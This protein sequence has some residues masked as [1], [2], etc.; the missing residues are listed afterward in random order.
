MEVEVKVK[1]SLWMLGSSLIRFMP[2]CFG[3]SGHRV[4]TRDVHR[5]RTHL[6]VRLPYTA[7]VWEAG[8]ELYGTVRVRE[9]AV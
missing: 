7:Y 8:S 5:N 3:T 9:K 6:V 2:I 4:E 1:S